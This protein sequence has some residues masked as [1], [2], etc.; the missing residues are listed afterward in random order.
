MILD[1]PYVDA[2]WLRAAGH[3]GAGGAE[4]GECLAIGCP[5]SSSASSSTE[6]VVLDWLDG[7]LGVAR[8]AVE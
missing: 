3:S 5:R 6:E 2:Q 7:I 8:P 1:D 4:L